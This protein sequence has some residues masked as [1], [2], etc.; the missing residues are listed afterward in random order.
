MS[1][2]E[3]LNNANNAAGQA[4]YD[5]VIAAK[6]PIDLST[7]KTPQIDPGTLQP[8]GKL[9]A[10]TD[11]PASAIKQYITNVNAELNAQLKVTFKNIQSGSMQG[12]YAAAAV[13]MSETYKSIPYTAFKN[14]ERAADYV[15]LSRDAASKLPAPKVGDLKEM[16]ATSSNRLNLKAA[17]DANYA[18]LT[19]A[20]KNAIVSYTGA[21]YGDWNEALRLGKTESAAFKSAQ[22]MVKAFEKAAVD[23]P[24]GTTIWRGLGVGKGTY[25]SVIGGIIQDGSFNSGSYGAHPGGPGYGQSTWLRIAVPASGV[26]GMDVTTFSSFQSGER[27]IVIQNGVRYA[28]LK[29]EKFANF[30]DSNGK[31]HGSRTIVDV[32][33]LP[34]LPT[35]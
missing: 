9:V 17:S 34:H 16:T 2:K 25:D 26:K 13:S 18:K 15:V 32:I 3:A 6:G 21:S 33:A 8:T 7:V 4:I 22:T 23:I 20:E 5:A 24:A 1:S 10:V 11:L 14:A 35:A 12:G 19:Q 28:V 29:T 30:I 27:E 31:G